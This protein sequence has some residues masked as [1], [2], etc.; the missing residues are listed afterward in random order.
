M[1]ADAEL[2]IPKLGARGGVMPPRMFH[3]LPWPN[4]T[5]SVTWLALQGRPPLAMLLMVCTWMRDK[6]CPAND[7][8]TFAP[9][10]GAIG[11]LGASIAVVVADQFH[12]LSRTHHPAT[13]GRA[14]EGFP[15][16]ACAHVVVPWMQDPLS[17]VLYSAHLTVANILEES[18]LNLVMV[19]LA[20]DMLSWSPDL[21]IY[22]TTTNGFWLAHQVH[23]THLCN[24]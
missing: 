16:L 11:M 2:S 23:K 10:H 18:A 21:T 13:A 4:E 6:L 24:V 3:P 9:T 14:I 7:Q 15:Q 19:A 1:L 20:A 5:A 17:A 22:V 8:A 12:P